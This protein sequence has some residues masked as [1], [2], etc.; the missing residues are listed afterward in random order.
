MASA[1]EQHADGEP[2][3]TI[4]VLGA[5][6]MGGGIAQVAAAL[7]PHAKVPSVAEFLDRADTDA[8][9]RGF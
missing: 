1:D 9:L 3:R 6:Q 8:K 5:G 4:G 2:A 7:R